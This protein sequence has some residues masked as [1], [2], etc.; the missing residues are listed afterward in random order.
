MPNRPALARPTPGRSSRDA[1][2]YDSCRRL[3]ASGASTSPIGTLSQ[4]IQCHEM[5]E[6]TA[7]PTSGPI[8]TARPLMPPHAPSARPRRSGGTAAERIVSVSG[9]TIAPPSP[10][11]ARAAS[12]AAI[13]GASA[14]AAEASVKMPSPIANM[15]RR[16]KRSPS[17]APVRRST[18]KVSVYAFTVHSRPESPELRSSRITGSAVVTTRLSSVTMKSASDVIANVHHIPALLAL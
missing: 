14:A 9:I 15:R 7:P 3:S 12:S 17:A 18:A 11:T 6:T 8:A 5:P 16:P 1:G 10:C 2:P 4:K 13:D